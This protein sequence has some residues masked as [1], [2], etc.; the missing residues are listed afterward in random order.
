M[1]SP[2]PFGSSAKLLCPTKR[3]NKANSGVAHSFTPTSP[4]CPT[5]SEQHASPNC[6]SRIVYS[7]LG[8]L[9]SRIG[10]IG[11]IGAL[12]GVSAFVSVFAASPW[13][14]SSCPWPGSPSSSSSPRRWCSRSSPGQRSAAWHEEPRRR[15]QGCPMAPASESR[16]FETRLL[17]WECSPRINQP[18]SISMGV[19]GFKF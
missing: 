4:T 11:R 6:S 16:D 5:N 14:T 13:G 10:R 2:S 17:S 7:L 19:P 12:L 3:P 8:R 9:D 15:L 1:N 18:R